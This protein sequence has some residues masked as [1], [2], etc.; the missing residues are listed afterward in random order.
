MVFAVINCMCHIIQGNESDVPVVGWMKT[1]MT[2]PVSKPG[3]GGMEYYFE[4]VKKLAVGNDD[5]IH[6]IIEL[7]R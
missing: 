6:T 1:F 2:E 4:F 3:G 7:K 5:A